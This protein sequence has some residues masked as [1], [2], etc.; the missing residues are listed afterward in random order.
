MKKIC[1]LVSFVLAAVV[2]SAQDIIVFRNADELSVNVTTVAPTTVSYTKWDNPNGPTYV[3]NKSDVFYIK[4]RNGDKDVFSDVTG[5]SAKCSSASVT[6]SRIN[7]VRLQSYIYGGAIFNSATAGPTVDLGIGIR[8]YDY[9]YAGIETGFHCGFS[10]VSYYG[11]DYM[12]SLSRT[13]SECYVP[14]AV[15]LKG[16]IPVGKKI[17][18]Y[19]NCSLG[20]FVGVKDIPFDGFY[21][22]VGAG[23]DIK[24]F[25]IGVGYSGLVKYGTF[26][27]GY[28]KVG[29][30]LGKW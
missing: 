30:R 27:C 15:N 2:A 13:V 10:T 12:D 3:V 22:Q 7:G 8:V 5:N 26:S 17:Y 9:F 18:P 19:I 28:V 11:D 24:R 23:I 4:Y 16:Y 6:G 14:V 1:T 20:G 25:S 29:V 21:C